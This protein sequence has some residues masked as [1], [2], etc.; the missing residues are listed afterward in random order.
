MATVDTTTPWD[1]LTANEKADR[2]KFLLGALATWLPRELGAEN[3][4]A[5]LRMLDGTAKDP[6]P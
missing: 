4:A 2:M 3:I 6:T 5:L 1:H